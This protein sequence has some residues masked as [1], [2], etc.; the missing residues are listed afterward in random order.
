MLMLNI[1]FHN[2]RD[3]SMANYQIHAAAFHILGSKYIKHFFWILVEK[4]TGKVV[5][6]LHGLATNPKD[7]QQKPKA[8]GVWGDMLKAYHFI[9]DRHFAEQ[10]QFYYDDRF[11]LKI[12][13]HVKVYE[14]SDVLD[15]WKKAVLAIDKFNCLEVKYSPFGIDFFNPKETN[16]SN[17]VFVTMQEVMGLNFDFKLLGSERFNIGIQKSYA[18]M[19]EKPNQTTLV[20]SPP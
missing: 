15:K 18:H 19:L 7:P 10:N 2:F 13:E 17:T 3:L 6:Q 16:N 9:Y 8:V 5:A 4:E 14:G 1:K 11:S 20:L 12:S